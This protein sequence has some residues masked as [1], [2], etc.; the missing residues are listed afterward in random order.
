[1]TDPAPTAVLPTALADPD[2]EPAP[3]AE[4]GTDAAAPASSVWVAPPSAPP[5][6]TPMSRDDEAP[7]RRLTVIDPATL[8]L[9]RLDEQLLWYSRAARRTRVWY[10]V[11]KIL[12]LVLA[13]GVPLAVAVGWPGGVTGALGAAVVVLEGVQ[14]LFQFQANWVRYSSARSGL[15]RQK[16]LF[17]AQA[18]E[19]GDDATRV[20]LLALRT[21]DVVRSETST[22]S[23]GSTRVPVAAN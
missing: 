14:Q 10:Q 12:Q 23:S 9:T 1:M 2:T 18:G 22:W 6:A 11:L 21:E 20:Q 5:A 16:F 13:A 8:V 4:P 7:T 3:D 17:L 19:Y 15:E